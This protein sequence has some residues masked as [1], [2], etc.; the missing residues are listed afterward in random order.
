MLKKNS[1]VLLQWY[2]TLASSSFVKGNSLFVVDDEANAASPNTLV[3]SHRVSTINSRL[4]NI[5]DASDIDYLESKLIS[6][7]VEAGTSDSDNKKK[8]NREKVDEFR[9]AELNQYLDEALFLLE[10]VSVTVLNLESEEAKKLA[11][12]LLLTRMIMSFR[13]LQNK[14]KTVSRK[15]KIVFPSYH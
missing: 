15:T 6:L 12:K 4:T 1:K 2:N 11:N 3:N 10:I 7:A 13:E 5:R 14:T 8:G 9:E